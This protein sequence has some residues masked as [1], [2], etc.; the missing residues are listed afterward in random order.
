MMPKINIQNVVSVVKTEQLFDLKAIGG[1]LTYSTYL[2]SMEC[3]I[4]KP[5]RHVGTF[6]IFRSGKIVYTGGPS[7]SYARVAPIKLLR[8]MENNGIVILKKPRAEVVNIVAT[9]NFDGKLNIEEIAQTLDKVIYE[10]E[11]FPAL[12]YRLDEPRTTFLI[13]SSGKLVCTGAKSEEDATKAIN[14]VFEI[15]QEKNLI[16]P[17]IVVAADGGTPQNCKRP[18][19]G[20]GRSCSFF[21]CHEGVDEDSLDCRFC[22]CPFY[23]CLDRQLG[24][25]TP[26]G[27]WDCSDCILPHIPEI[28]DY[29]RY[30]EDHLFEVV[31][32]KYLKYLN[33][34]V[35][36]TKT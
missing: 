23:P 11:Q 33:G 6:L 25:M 22:Y 26:N 29:I 15:F 8:I 19:G 32:A 3:L 21:P 12:I 28:A 14:K 31:K 24:K 36:L 27:N 18:L 1:I 35:C 5:R 17:N 9:T 34:R 20:N 7:E 2:P 10:P 30:L 16:A 4:Y 13:F